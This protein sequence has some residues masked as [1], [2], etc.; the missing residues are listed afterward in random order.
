[1]E[2]VLKQITLVASLMAQVSIQMEQD[3]EQMEQV[4][5]QMEQVPKQ[6]RDLR[7]QNAVGGRFAAQVQAIFW[8]LH[9]ST[10]KPAPLTPG[11]YAVHSKCF[12]NLSSST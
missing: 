7:H 9:R 11:T 3:M 6:G 5:E 4:M 12:M 2:P 8:N 10:R 1:M